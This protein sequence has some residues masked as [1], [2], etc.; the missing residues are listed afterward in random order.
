MGALHAGHAANIQAACEGSDSVVVSI[1]ANPLQFGSAEEWLKYPRALDADFDLCQSLGVD[2]VWAPDVETMYPQGGV[3]VRVAA[4]ESA[5]Q[6]EGPSRPGH[7]DGMLT[8]V[9]KLFGSVRPDQ[10][11]FGEK[12]YQQLT[13]IRRMVSDLDMPVDVRSVSTVR[14]PDGL[15][16]SS[17][18]VFLS[19][20]QRQDAV[21]L[22]RALVAGQRAAGSAE[23]VLL[24]ARNALAEAEGIVVDY[25]ELR[26][27]D[28]GSAPLSGA[29]RLLVAGTIGGIRLIDNAPIELSTPIELNAAIELKR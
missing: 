15:A 2:L 1:F 27:V 24:A 25:L 8:V 21:A 5:N 17:R 12:D 11:F 22:S 10:A 18:N 19:E 3:Q 29:A 4:G 9:A 7:F 23:A 28:L 26:D 6:L 13:L 14:E 16:L 20:E